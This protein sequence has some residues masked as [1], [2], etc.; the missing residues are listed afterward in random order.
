[1][2]IPYCAMPGKMKFSLLDYCQEH[3]DYFYKIR[4]NHVLRELEHGVQR[5][6]I[7]LYFEKW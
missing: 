5:A 2:D 6:G 4:I 1:M 3:N 7:I